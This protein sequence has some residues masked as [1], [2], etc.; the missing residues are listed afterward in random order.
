MGLEDRELIPCATPCVLEALA[1]NA[2]AFRATEELGL[3]GARIVTVEVGSRE[4]A[5][6]MDCEKHVVHPFFFDGQ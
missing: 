5:E 2:A 4:I 1:G 3:R 6:E